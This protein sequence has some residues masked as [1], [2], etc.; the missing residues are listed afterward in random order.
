MGLQQC[1]GGQ[2][3]SPGL[4]VRENLGVY[5]HRARG[6]Q[7]QKTRVLG[8]FQ[9]LRAIAEH[10][11]TTFGVKDPTPFDL[12]QMCDQSRC[13][14]ALALSESL[15][16]IEQCCV[17]ELRRCSGHEQSIRTNFACAQTART[18]MQSH[19]KCFRTLF[20]LCVWLAGILGE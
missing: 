2:I 19:G 6:S 11:R 13:G 5:S 9:D 12:G 16:R 4:Q 14:R 20:Q 10:R 15:D 3:Q 8:K 18:G 17:R 7:A 1:H